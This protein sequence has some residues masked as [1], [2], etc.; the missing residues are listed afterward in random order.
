MC[1]VNLQ[2]SRVRLYPFFAI[3]IDIVLLM[4]TLFTLGLTP[5]KRHY[6][7]NS[8]VKLA[9]LSTPQCHWEADINK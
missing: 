8:T 4:L 6:R 9:F 7:P 5:P 1:I 3:S 2:R